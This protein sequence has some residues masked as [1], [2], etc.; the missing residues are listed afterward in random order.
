MKH[1]SLQERKE[2]IH[3][4][5]KYENHADR[6][7]PGVTMKSD[8]DARCKNSHEKAAYKGAQQRTGSAVIN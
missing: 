8:I 6:N 7:R 2:E 4:E 3:Q 5:Q 1:T